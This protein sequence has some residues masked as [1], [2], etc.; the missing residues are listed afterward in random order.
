MIWTTFR[1][2]MAAALN[3]RA[4][5]IESLQHTSIRYHKNKERVTQ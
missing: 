4:A 5:E 2:L 1:P 3:R